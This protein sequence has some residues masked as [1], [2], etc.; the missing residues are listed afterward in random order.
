MVNL[1]VIYGYASAGA[2][3][4]DGAPVTS[5]ALASTCGLTIQVAEAFKHYTPHS[6]SLRVTDDRTRAGIESTRWPKFTRAGVFG[7]D[8]G[9]HRPLCFPTE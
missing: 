1:Y 9:T 5:G 6:A 8:N 4:I 7:R 2:G 3:G